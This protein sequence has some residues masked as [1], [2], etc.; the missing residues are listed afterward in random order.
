MDLDVSFE[1]DE[2][3]ELMTSTVVVHPWSAFNAYGEPTYSATG[4]TY[5][6]RLEERPTLVQS[7]EGREV[8]AAYTLFIA[9]TSALNATDRF[10][11]ADGTVPDLQHL[12]RVYDDDGIHHH[13]AYFGRGG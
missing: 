12:E 4:S 3:T 6:C 2:F 10:T 1:R 11:L 8:L 7:L 5:A 13:V 9:S